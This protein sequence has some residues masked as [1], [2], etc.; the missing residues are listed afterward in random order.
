MRMAKV[1]QIFV[2]RTCG[3]AQSRWMGKCPDCGAWDSLEQQRVEKSAGADPQRGLIEAW[4][5]DPKGEAE[6]AGSGAE[7]RRIGE[8][9][10]GGGPAPRLKTGIG[11][12]DRVLGGGLVPGSVVLVGGDPGIGKSTLMLQAAGAMGRA[13]GVGGRGGGRGGG[14]VRL[15]RG[16]GRAGAVAGF[17][18]GR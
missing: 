2:C 4:R 14:A 13:G 9:G 5:A 3:G 12:L 18:F 11:E 16:V 17:A 1:R 10:P 7:A 15:E 8:V 6:G